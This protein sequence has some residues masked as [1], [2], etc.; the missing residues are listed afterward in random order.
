MGMMKDSLK[1]FLCNDNGAVSVDWVVLTAS[2][3]FL[4]VSTVAVVQ[5]ASVS[6]GNQILDEFQQ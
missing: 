3:V 4:A 2:V 6:T 1:R 5:A